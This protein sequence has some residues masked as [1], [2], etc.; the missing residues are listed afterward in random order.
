MDVTTLLPGEI[1]NMVFHYLEPKDRKAVVL[2]C[3]RWKDEGEDPRL[4]SWVRITVT[5]TNIMMIPAVLGWRRLQ[6][7]RR[8]VM[9]AVSEFS[10]VRDERK[11]DER[12][13]D[14]EVRIKKRKNRY[15]I[16]VEIKTQRKEK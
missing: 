13:A 5:S 3:H 16:D 4:W 10:K 14:K 7:V 12:K 11:A 2:V 1:L 8:I 6:A 15:V 9:R